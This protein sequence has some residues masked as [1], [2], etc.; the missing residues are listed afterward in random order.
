MHV[1][2]PRTRR[3][4]TGR[5]SIMPANES[6]DDDIFDSEVN[7]SDEYKSA[8]AAEVDLTIDDEAG[9]SENSKRNRSIVVNNSMITKTPNAKRFSGIGANITTSPIT[10]TPHRSTPDIEFSDKSNESK[11]SDIEIN[12]SHS[13]QE[14]KS[15]ADDSVVLLNSSDESDLKPIANST[16]VDLKGAAAFTSTPGNSKYV[17]P[18]LGFPRNPMKMTK[19][20]VSR[21]FYNHEVDE[22]TKLKL[23]V[24]ENEELFTK[25]LSSLPDGGVNMKR[26]ISEIKK[27]IDK[28]QERIDSYAIEEDNLD[29]IEIVETKN[30]PKTH[31]W[32]DELNEIKPRHTGQQGMATFNTQKALTLNRIEK[33]HKA[34]EKCPTETD[35]ANQ[36]DNLNIALMPH[37]LHAI[38]WMR[39][40]EI[41]RP[42]GGL[43]ADD[44]G[45]GKT[46][47]AQMTTFS[48]KLWHNFFQVKH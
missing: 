10:S 40:R 46:Y 30:Q 23:E 13:D 26:R 9:H 39:W 32:R 28:K 16:T 27:K 24:K 29:E 2:S 42:K 8:E 31:D 38:K 47:F 5:R 12:S 22:L 45:L 4:I 18:K 41:Q 20:Y 25:L 36:P 34:M 35:F 19:N 15:I 1:F 21:A 3:T 43:L 7:S 44:M 11:A 17:Q 33:L 48:A 6:E 14:I 37:Q